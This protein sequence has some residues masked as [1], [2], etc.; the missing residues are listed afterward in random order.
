VATW[1]SYTKFILGSDQMNSNRVILVRGKFRCPG[2]HVKCLWPSN[3]DVELM[4]A[5]EQDNGRITERQFN[6]DEGEWLLVVEAEF[7]T[8]DLWNHHYYEARPLQPNRPGEPFLDE[9]YIWP[10]RN[11]PLWLQEFLKGGQRIGL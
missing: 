4:E 9:K 11:H 5:L 6:E 1:S 2:R 7:Y 8:P 10:E 3:V